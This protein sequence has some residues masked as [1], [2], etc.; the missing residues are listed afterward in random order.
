MSI[1]TED[2][3]QWHLDKRVPIAQMITVLVAIISGAWAISESYNELKT[4]KEDVGELK[5]KVK[6]Y[7]ARDLRTAERLISLEEQIKY[8]NKLLEQMLLKLNI[9]NVQKPELP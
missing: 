5:E 7:D 4:V 6:A 3:K 2:E 8:N 9:K 1:L